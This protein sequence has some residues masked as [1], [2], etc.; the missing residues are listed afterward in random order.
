MAIDPRLELARRMA[1]GA[2][3]GVSPP[4]SPG[5][6][7][8]AAGGGD[9]KSR[10]A[11]NYAAWVQRKKQQTQQTQAAE[12]PGGFKGIVSTLLDNPIAKTALAPLAAIDYGR[13]GIISGLK[14]IKDSIDLDPN[15]EFSAGDFNR[16]LQDKIGFGDVLG[17]LFPDTNLAGRIGNRTIGFL[18]DVAFDPVTYLTAGTGNLASLTGRVG[19]ASDI[20]LKGSAK[21]AAG[22]IS[23]EA[24]ESIVQRAGKRGIGKLTPAERASFNLPKAG[25]Y[26]GAPFS[27]TAGAGV[28]LGGEKLGQALGSG[29]SSLKGGFLESKIL[30]PLTTTSEGFMRKAPTGIEEVYT[31]L[32]TGRGAI[33]AT[34]AASVLGGI[35]EKA[36]KGGAFTGTWARVADGLLKDIT[37]EP[38]LT[39]LTHA[40]EGGSTGVLPSA[41][42]KL[43]NDVRTSWMETTGKEIGNVEN[44]V[45]HQWTKFGRELLSGDTKIGQDL[46]KAFNITVDEVQKAGPTFERKLTAGTYDIGGKKITFGKG[47]IK[48]IGDTLKI[49]FP[50][51][52][53][54]P[55]LEENFRKIVG[56]YVRNMGQGVGDAALEQRLKNM[57]VTVSRNEAMRAVV[58]KG[59]TRAANEAAA[60]EL[61]TALDGGKAAVAQAKKDASMSVRAA[62]DSVGATL[63]LKVSV[64]RRQDGALAGKWNKLADT[65]ASDTLSFDAKAA[66]MNAA[67]LEVRDD[68][69]R[70]LSVFDNLKA[71]FDADIAQNGIDERM[72]DKTRLAARKEAK[73]ALA[74]ADAR[75]KHLTVQSEAY[76]S[77][78]ETVASLKKDLDQFTDVITPG[79]LPEGARNAVKFR[80]VAEQAVADTSGSAGNEVVNSVVRLGT[81]GDAGFGL[82]KRLRIDSKGASS[83]LRQT[84][85][86]A[87]RVLDEP[88]HGPIGDVKNLIDEFY[89]STSQ[90]SEAVLSKAQKNIDRLVANLRNERNLL[91]QKIE[92]GSSSVGKSETRIRTIE[93]QLRNAREE[94]SAMAGEVGRTEGVRPRFTPYSDMLPGN[95]AEQQKRQLDAEMRSVVE[96]VRTTV[97]A[98]VSVDAGTKQAKMVEDLFKS[99]ETLA[100]SNGEP[101]TAAYVVAA[102]NTLDKSIY[103]ARIS[104]DFANRYKAV[105]NEVK[106]VGHEVTPEQSR[107]LQDMVMR[108]VLSSE[109]RALQVSQGELADSLTHYAANS[110]VKDSVNLAKTKAMKTARKEAADTFALLQP[111]LEEI[112]KITDDINYGS[113]F[114]ASATSSE[115]LGKAGEEFT[116][117]GYSIVSGSVEQNTFNLRRQAG[118]DLREA[119]SY[120][121]FPDDV[122]A[123]KAY[124]KSGEVE[125]LVQRITRGLGPEAEKAWTDEIIRIR[126]GQPLN[127]RASAQGRA[128]M[129]LDASARAADKQI[130]EMEARIGELTRTIDGL[131]PMNAV[132]PGSAENRATASFFEGQADIYR[133][134]LKQL[135]AA[136]T[137]Q[138]AAVDDLKYK[139]KMFSDAANARL[140]GGRVAQGPKLSAVDVLQGKTS[141]TVGVVGKE[142][143]A[144]R[145]EIIRLEAGMDEIV[146]KG[147]LAGRVK[148][149]EGGKNIYN[150][151]KDYIKVIDEEVAIISERIKRIPVEQRK[152]V[153]AY[154]AKLVAE[155]KALVKA[156]DNAT[157]IEDRVISAR[158]V[159]DEKKAAVKALAGKSNVQA[160]LAAS[161]AGLR[162]SA[163]NIV[164]K[165]SGVEAK[166]AVDVARVE[167]GRAALRDTYDAT[168]AATRD[169]M[170]VIDDVRA[171]IQADL[172]AF[173]E[174]VRLLPKGKNLEKGDTVEKL[175]AL[176]NYIG[177]SY[178][179]L[180][181]EG[182]A[183]RLMNMPEDFTI[184]ML[185][186]N[187]TLNIGVSNP[188]LVGFLQSLPDEPAV[189]TALALIYKAHEDMGKLLSVMDESSALAAQ[190]KSANKGKLFSVLKQVIKDGVQ[191][192]ADSGLFVPDEVANAMKRLVE[193]NG[194]QQN[195]FMMALNSYVDIW[196]AVKTTSP[197]FHVRNGMSATF[198]NFVADVKFEH[199]KAGTQYWQWFEADPLNWLSKVPKERRVYA[200]AALE[201]VFASGGGEY[202]EVAMKNTR[203]SQKGV[204]RKSRNFGGKVEGS[205]RMG[206]ALDSR[207]P[208]EMGGK[209]M[210]ADLSAARIS[211]YHFNYSQL[212]QFDRNAKLFIPFWTF[213]SRNAPLQIEQMWMNP[214][215]Y[216]IYNS[217]VRNLRDEQE[218]DVTPQ[219]IS[220]TG[221][222]KLPFGENLYGT[223]DIGMNRVSQDIAQLRDP[224][225]LAQNLNPVFKTGLELAM[226]KQ[227]YKDIPIRGDQYQEL[228]GVNRLAALPLQLFGGGEKDPTTGKTVFSDKE[229]YG[230][231]ALVPGLQE[232]NRYITPNTESKK[233]K[234]NMNLLS[235]LTGLPA[236]KVTASQIEAESNRVKREKAKQIAKKKAIARGANK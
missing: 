57:G 60:V 119:M 199:M 135:N 211:K 196:K 90:V 30:K 92:A 192:L 229:V 221:G 89:R 213:M 214:R 43:F 48:D 5:A 80:T 171:G 122:T 212:S 67:E 117:P 124:A 7:S 230:L 97:S 120:I 170:K 193:L 70:A 133:N 11:A 81:Q 116:N 112:Q 71:R 222:F 58:D 159:L 15:T 4:P 10:S 206:M 75:V 16:Q 228:S 65:L 208:V 186:A 235:F 59:A 52:V 203:L 12:G 233:D 198:M 25:I 54:E 98:Q 9:L 181:P 38:S 188:E 96:S 155:R 127:S 40:V 100:R 189:R 194:K 83:T 161:T 163:D 142:H 225:R 136:G 45:P 205:V 68:L 129:W 215:A 207:L 99:M 115:I 49:A 44:Y 148:D 180:D 157:P 152:E 76:A 55:V 94:F 56:T 8:I 145:A 79:N 137:K 93:T 176:H 150:K 107:M 183:A 73:R 42:R 27:K 220:E 109:K 17:N 126:S 78:S 106:L 151:A 201:D 108:E 144:I 6:S 37:D 46:R 153:G 82:T 165:R 66:A 209:A 72:L 195:D 23:K 123:A 187:N 24:L 85:D 182:L 51:V 33:S 13:A 19:L 63:K 110:G 39:A 114:G 175:T 20:A 130:V 3:R 227:F 158:V 149:V 103:E 47:T 169:G 41:M 231:E 140:V 14:E 168:V 104:T 95:V 174:Q 18:G 88:F 121:L 50:D 224:M 35:T 138:G 31:K 147:A 217:A 87:G 156:L 53:K 172:P 184:D 154:R 173:E 234:Q 125:K 118:R 166:G 134:K 101:S 236:T 29:I 223:P 111:Y 204:F 164:A 74:E 139:I 69:D 131:R 210:G 64:L 22:E 226:G 21:V 162:A 102:Q 197:R 190:L 178:D 128:A 32:A 191:E 146:N 91:E 177:D 179:L 28:Y 105:M 62:L 219:Y 200:K 34:H 26:F 141:K 202:S 160:E 84:V 216:A 218:G 132:S 1:S 61:K 86:A 143:Q 2:V 113:G 167:A 185:K 232:I 77:M 36:A